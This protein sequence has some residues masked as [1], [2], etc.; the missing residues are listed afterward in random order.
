MFPSV[1]VYNEGMTILM[2]MMMILNMIQKVYILTTNL[3]KKNY[4]NVL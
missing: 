4:K 1:S 3:I 2:M